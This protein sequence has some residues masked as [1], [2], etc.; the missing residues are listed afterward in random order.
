MKFDSHCKTCTACWFPISAAS[1][2]KKIVAL[3]DELKVQLFTRTTRKVVVTPYGVSLY[4]RCVDILR[5][6]E[7]A[8]AA[9]RQM[10]E[11]ASGRVRMILP[12]SFGRGLS[13]I[14]Y[15][16]AIPGWKIISASIARLL[17]TP[18]VPPSF[19]QCLQYL[20]FVPPNTSCRTRCILHVS[21]DNMPAIVINRLLFR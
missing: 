9:M 10:S 6:L 13:C 20:Q 1:V 19:A 15:L 12:Y 14:T 16:E 4:D 18:Q 21:E 11:S 7:D 17:H 8:E 3:E 5:R 2:T